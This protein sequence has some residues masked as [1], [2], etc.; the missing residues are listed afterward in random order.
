MNN[1]KIKAALFTMQVFSI[2]AT[3]F[4]LLMLAKFY[5]NTNEMRYVALALCLSWIGYVIYKIKLDDLEDH[6]RKITDIALRLA[7]KQRK[8]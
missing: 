5:E 3:A 8:S 1:L 7:E 6:D 4:A 2:A